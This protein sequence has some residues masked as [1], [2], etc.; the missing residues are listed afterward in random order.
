LVVYILLGNCCLSR[1]SK[2]LPFTGIEQYFKMFKCLPL[3]YIV[4]LIPHHSAWLFFF[5]LHS[6]LNR[7]WKLIYFISLFMQKFCDDSYFL[8]CCW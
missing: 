3:C 5:P 7:T 4:L 1:F 2:L 8:F 6:Y